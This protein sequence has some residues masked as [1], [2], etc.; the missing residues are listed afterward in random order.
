VLSSLKTSLIG[1]EAAF[2]NII[3]PEPQEY[4]VSNNPDKEQR[5][6]ALKIP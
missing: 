4:L 1:K 6:M 3:P 5:W 2:S